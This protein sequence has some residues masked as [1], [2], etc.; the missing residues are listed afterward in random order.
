MPEQKQKKEFLF[1]VHWDYHSYSGTPPG[2]SHSYS[3]YRELFVVVDKA[4]WG[5]K[6]QLNHLLKER[7]RELSDIKSIRQVTGTREV[8]I[9]FD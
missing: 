2:E 7:G 4:R 1:I 5:L 3:D 6:Q 9:S 8:T